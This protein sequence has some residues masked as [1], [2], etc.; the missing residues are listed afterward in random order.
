VPNPSQAIGISR[1]GSSVVLTW[2]SGTLLQ[3]PAVTGPWTTNNAAVSPYT[4]PATSGNLFFKT[5]Q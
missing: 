2:T 5:I 1:S 4:V 3:A